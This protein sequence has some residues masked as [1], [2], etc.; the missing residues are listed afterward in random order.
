MKNHEISYL[1]EQGILSI[2]SHSL[3]ADAAYKVFKF[4]KFINAAMLSIGE[5]ERGLLDEVGI[6]DVREFDTRRAKLV[7]AGDTEGIQEMNAQM[8]SFIKLKNELMMDEQKY[9]G[10]KLTW[11]EWKTLQDENQAIEVNGKK[12]DALS[13]PVELLLE[14][15]LW[16]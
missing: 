11:E 7:E 6:K 12:I 14:G 16:E 5:A 2:K 8:A 13:G 15:N 1:I 4:R 3:N 10:P 9:D